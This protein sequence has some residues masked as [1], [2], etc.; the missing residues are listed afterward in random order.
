M[1]KGFSNNEYGT[2]VSNHTCDT[3]GND[4]T[5]CPAKDKDSTSF[6]D[7]LALECGSYDPNRDADILFMSD[8]EIA[9]T[10][11]VISMDILRTRKQMIKKD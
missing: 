2:K 6:N 11:S 4:F 7:C 1:H 9:A 10:R 3:C 8:K 5:V